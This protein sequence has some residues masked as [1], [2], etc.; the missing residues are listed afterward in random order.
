MK[1]V[2]YWYYAGHSL[3]RGGATWAYNAGVPVDTMRILGDCC[4]LGDYKSK[5]YTAYTLSQI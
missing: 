3:R 2:M 4:I 1:I 5:A